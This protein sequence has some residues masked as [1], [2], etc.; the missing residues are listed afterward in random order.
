MPDSE[1]TLSPPP[2]TIPSE[3]FPVL[4]S[5][6]QARVLAHGRHRTVEPNEVVVELNE[7]VTKV[8]GSKGTTASAAV[9]E[10][11]G[12]RRR[13]LQSG[14]VHGRTNV[15]SGRRGPVG[16]RAVEKSG[17]IEIEREAWG[18]DGG[19]TMPFTQPSAMIPELLRPPR[20]FERLSI[21]V[22]F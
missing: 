8:F 16:I 3:M 5:A 20:K 10:Q 1:D 15:L 14:H 11:S 17:L 6:Q 9:L 13:H 22:S 19:G 2:G 12:A 4:T 18:E 21:S 7:H